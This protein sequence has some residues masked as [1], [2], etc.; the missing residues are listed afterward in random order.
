[1]P[2][3]GGL[4]VALALRE[5]LAERGRAGGHAEAE[6]IERG[7]RGDRARQDEGQ[8]GERRHHGVRQYRCRQMM[9][10]L[11]DTPSARLRQR[12]YSKFL[13]RAGTRRGRHADETTPTR[14]AS[15]IA[16]Q[17]VQN[18]GRQDRAAMMMQDVERAASSAQISM[19]RCINKIESLPP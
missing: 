18:P 3:P 7:Q 17:H 9:V 5:Q 1:M 8:E 4:E 19:I 2:E 15:M 6:E 14:T 16:E 13:A 12:T 10:G 11:A